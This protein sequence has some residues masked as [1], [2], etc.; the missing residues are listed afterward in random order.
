MLGEPAPR[1]ATLAFFGE[2]VEAREL[3]R[4]IVEHGTEATERAAP[5]DRVLQAGRRG[6]DP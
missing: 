3:V 2:A 1:A 6:W 4:M 5:V